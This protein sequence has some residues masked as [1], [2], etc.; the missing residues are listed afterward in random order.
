MAELGDRR[1]SPDALLELAAHEKRGRLKI[2]IGASPGVGKTY[3]MLVVANEKL[4]DGVNVLAG[5]VETHGRIET[6]E[7]LKKNLLFN[8]Y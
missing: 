6:D 4:Q 7:L 1:P 8:K 5:V 2:F 3:A